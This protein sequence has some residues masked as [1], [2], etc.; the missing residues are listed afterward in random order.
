MESDLLDSLGYC[1]CLHCCKVCN[2]SKTG[3]FSTALGSLIIS[4]L[5]ESRMLFLALKIVCTNLLRWIFFFFYYAICSLVC[6]FI[7]NHLRLLVICNVCNF[8]RQFSVLILQYHPSVILQ[9]NAVILRR[10]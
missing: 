2:G 10:V 6:H 8:Y 7:I 3:F 4:L 9:N 1:F 5:S